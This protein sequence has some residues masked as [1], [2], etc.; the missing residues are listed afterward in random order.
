M[1]KKIVIGTDGSERSMRVAQVAGNLASKHKECKIYVMYVVHELPT[2]VTAILENSN[3]HYGSQMKENA[4][5]ILQRTV[6]ALCVDINDVEV[7]T[8]LE[9]GKAANELIK[10]AKEVK[11]DLMVVGNSSISEAEE[12]LTGSGISHKVMHH[13]PCHVLVVK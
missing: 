7:H 9:Y 13:A 1:F 2:F 5:E 3:I 4:K 6:Q 10:K 8:I 12:F 11:A